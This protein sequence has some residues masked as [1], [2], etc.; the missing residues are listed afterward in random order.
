MP[1]ATGSFDGFANFSFVLL[2]GTT[3]HKPLSL[4]ITTTALFLIISNG[5][6]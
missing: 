3:V 1:L 6:G 2:I 4:A 5:I